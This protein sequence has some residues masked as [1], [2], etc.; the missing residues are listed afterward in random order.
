MLRELEELLGHFEWMTNEFESNVV[1]SSKV[2]PCIMTLKHRIMHNIN[3]SI[4][5]EQ[6]RRD[7]HKSLSNRFGD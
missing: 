3:D 7:L 2:Y 6:L 5:T 1:S 4:Y